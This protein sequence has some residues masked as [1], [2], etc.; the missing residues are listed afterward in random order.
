MINASRRQ[1]TNTFSPRVPGFPAGAGSLFG[2]MTAPAPRS[3]SGPPPALNRRARKKAPWVA[4][5][6][7]ETC[8]GVFSG[9]FTAAELATVVVLAAVVAFIV[10]AG[11]GVLF[12]PPTLGQ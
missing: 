2:Q 6:R 8:E 3:V 5:H 1:D 12:M 7:A 11:L 10:G 4:C 9:N